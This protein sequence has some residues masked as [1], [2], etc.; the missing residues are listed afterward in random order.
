MRFPGRMCKLKFH[1]RTAARF[2]KDARLP[3]RCNLGKHPSD[4][5]SVPQTTIALVY[6]YDQ[7]L[8]PTYMQDDVLF[9]AYGINPAAFWKKCQSLV[10][11][12]GWESELAYLKT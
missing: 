4:P 10:K 5:M 1:A 9:P 6:D 3:F 8:S 2:N 7:T 11:D 12:E